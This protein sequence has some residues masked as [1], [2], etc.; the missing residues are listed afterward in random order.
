MLGGCGYKRLSVRGFT[1]VV[2]ELEQLHQ[3]SSHLDCRVFPQDADV[4]AS[5]LSQEAYAHCFGNSNTQIHLPEMKPGEALPANFKDQPVLSANDPVARLYME[6]RK[7][8]GHV[9]NPDDFFGS[10]FFLDKDG[11][12]VT[13]FHVVTGQK[14]VDVTTD[15]GVVHHA[16]VVA[17][18][19]NND[20]ALLKV[21]KIKDSENFNPVHLAPFAAMTPGEQFVGAGFGSD[22]QLHVSPGSFDQMLLQ[23]DIKLSDRAPFLDPNRQLVHLEQHTVNGDSGGLEFRVSDGSVRLIIDATD[24][25][26]NTLAIPAERVIEL[27]HK[28]QE[29]QANRKSH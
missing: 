2:A 12:F 29:E 3:R 11:L 7:S 18:D 25:S 8:M 15:D 20:I 16:K 19:E 28:Y 10:G 6:A 14:D 21:Q 9:H 26:K 24:N 13:D 1:R 22:S 4:S 27:E 17:E 5:K 23:K